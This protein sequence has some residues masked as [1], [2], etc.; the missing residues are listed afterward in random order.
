MCVWFG[1]RTLD[2]KNSLVST[3]Y[4][5]VTACVGRGSWEDLLVIPFTFAF[6]ATAK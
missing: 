3:R 2:I 1:A 4:L 5:L 6:E